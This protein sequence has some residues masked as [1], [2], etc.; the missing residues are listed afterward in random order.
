MPRRKQGEEHIRNLQQVNG[1]YF[2][3][4]PIAY[5]R[6]LGWREHQKVEVHRAGKGLTVKDWKKK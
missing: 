1:T 4:I 6:E 5:I 3:T 2:V